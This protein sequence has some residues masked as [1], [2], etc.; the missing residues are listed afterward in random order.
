MSFNFGSNA[1][2]TSSGSTP[3]IFG[4]AA[5]KDASSTGGIFGNA[6]KAPATTGSIFGNPTSTAGQTTSA[7]G[8]PSPSTQTPTTSGFSF[9]SK[10]PTSGSN[11]TT[12]G[13]APASNPFGG[14]PASTGG[15]SFGNNSTTPA[16]TNKP[17]FSTTPA[18]P[19][20]T[21]STG[22]IFGG[23]PLSFGKPEEKTAEAPKS[24]PAFGAPLGGAANTFGSF[25]K[26][27]DDNSS[28]PSLFG[29]K[30]ADAAAPANKPMFNLGG[31]A[32]ST[33]Q[34]AP[35]T[36]PAFSL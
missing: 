7:F 23:K 36:A 11:P 32:S 15:L 6:N 20:P 8:A 29:Q 12:P 35:A 24:A 10:P 16:T 18:G 9:G 4:T 1:A 3:S 19:P 21:Q 5:N 31:A 30:P 2:G 22:G 27:A 26:K 25:G 14:A 33:P 17:M 13:V 34:S 28:A